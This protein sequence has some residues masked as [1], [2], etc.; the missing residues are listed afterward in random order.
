MNTEQSID[1]ILKMLKDSVFSES[2]AQTEQPKE[3]KQR[4]ISDQA[5]HKQLKSKYFSDASDVQPSDLTEDEYVIDSDFLAE[6]I[7]IDDVAEQTEGP[8]QIEYDEL[9]SV[10]AEETV[11]IEDVD[12]DAEI[13][14][15]KE[16]EE[17]EEIEAPVEIADVTA[18]EE[19]E[20]IEEIEA[21]EPELEVEAEPEQEKDEPTVQEAELESLEEIFEQ[22]PDDE[23]EQQ[24]LDV[25]IEQ[26]DEMQPPYELTAEDEPAEEQEIVEDVQD[27][28]ED[29]VEEQNVFDDEPL[30]QEDEQLIYQE[31]EMDADTESDEQIEETEQ[32]EQ[33]DAP[34][35]VEDIMLASAPFDIDEN[36]FIVGE[37]EQ[38]VDAE[39]EDSELAE[40]T[41]QPGIVDTTED[42]EEV[43]EELEQ[44][45]DE[46]DP[47]QPE[48]EDPL[49]YLEVAEDEE[50]IEQD[51]QIDEIESEATLVEVE[52][53]PE[54]PDPDPSNEEEIE[55]NA[56]VDEPDSQEQEPNEDTYSDLSVEQI[57]DEIISGGV[58]LAADTESEELEENAEDDEFFEDLVAVEQ[59]DELPEDNVEELLAN[60]VEIN[61]S[62][63]EDKEKEVP[64]EDAPVEQDARDDC[65]IDSPISVITEVETFSQHDTLLATMRRS[66]V[67]VGT[68]EPEQTELVESPD[69]QPE[70][71]VTQQDVDDMIDEALDMSTINIMMQ[72]CGKEE[73]DKTLGNEHVDDFLRQE[74]STVTA[75]PEGHVSDGKEYL[76]K[77]QTESI[78]SAYKRRATAKLGV[79]MG[80]VLLAIITIAYDLLPI[81]DVRLPSIMDY[82]AYP[83]VYALL[84]LQLLVFSIAIMHKSLWT[85]LKRAFSL[86]PN[87][88]S[89]GAVIA[90]ATVIYDAIIVLIIT[91]ADEDLPCL[92]NGVAALVVALCAF[93]DYIDTSAQ[94]RAFYVYSDDAKKFTLSRESAK[95]AIGAKMYAGGIDAS[96]GIYSIAPVDFPSGFFKNVG[97]PSRKKS[98]LRVCIIPA[99]ILGMIA[100]VVSIVLKMDSY[101]ASATFLICI[102]AITPLSVVVMDKLAC[103]LACR[104]LTKRA[105]AFAG[106]A[107]IERYADCDVMVF[108]DLHM[109]RKCKTED[110]G[111]AIYD[112]RVGYL[113][114]GCLQA[115]YSTIGGPLSGLN[116]DLPEVF[117]FDRVSIRRI[118]KNGV[119]A[120]VDGKH[121]IV[122]GE[123]EFLQRY[124]LEFPPNEQENG[125]STLC[126]SIN[127]GVSAKLSVK[128]QPEP[129]FEMLAER[130]SA[131]GISCAIHTFDPL[132][133]SAMI[134]DV[135]T[136][137]D[138]PISVIHGSTQDLADVNVRR[139]SEEGDGVIACSSRLKLAEVAVWL[140]RLTKVRKIFERISW[141]SA[142]LGATLLVLIMTLDAAAY[143]SFEHLSAFL[144]LQAAVCIVVYVTMMPR[145]SYFTVEA[146]YKE[147]ERQHTKMI[148]RE[149]SQ[150]K[151]TVKA[152]KNRRKKTDE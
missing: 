21:I 128:Y 78:R 118:T 123:R 3:K 60:M 42:D 92:Y 96:K 31:Q 83:A 2:D 6:A 106:E 143:V 84:G 135:R 141:V 56:P 77:K 81:L 64:R 23:D 54:V 113:V 91:F 109:F 152:P 71:M 137:G 102:Y 17:I 127:G 37:V 112:T 33:Y 105:S 44:Q 40:Q 19:I 30:E 34:L 86:M 120:V 131:E 104:T 43:F 101:S 142:A 12:E 79:A 7:Q 62:A 1:D 72:F 57:I 125:R 151:K 20:E 63:G 107:V 66:G 24:V 146:L 8:L 119:E 95:S 88:H 99:L 25:E 28:V 140:K 67:E 139:Y 103:D 149:E 129:L 10:S 51:L 94:M 69:L 122:V 38:T 15:I 11:E 41:E 82:R 35:T 132:I 145:K 36:T 70:E 47:E 93:G 130:L 5:L 58:A 49:T 90:A 18:D 126:I 108:G 74:N 136:L 150:E 76:D 14:E 80:C 98:F 100:T 75:R 87:R 32:E 53:E 124:G 39:L 111:M 134:A 148:K 61:H 65:R 115:L 121:S 114:L 138:S 68:Y 73:L 55:Q 16:I 27:D 147:L 26:E 144:L 116:I 29:I 22:T 48:A 89:A 46:I 4:S 13:E 52:P 85:G 45:F 50:Q 117:R 133:N 9:D 97:T 59:D 110:V